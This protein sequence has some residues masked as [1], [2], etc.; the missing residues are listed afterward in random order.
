M[1]PHRLLLHEKLLRSVAATPDLDLRC[2]NHCTA[3]TV[4]FV[5]EVRVQAEKKLRQTEENLRQAN[6]TQ[7]NRTLVWSTARPHVPRTDE[8]TL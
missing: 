4:W 2:P 5:T 8:H 1:P 7:N 6:R 3:T